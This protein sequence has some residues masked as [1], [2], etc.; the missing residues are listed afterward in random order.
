VEDKVCKELDRLQAHLEEVRGQIE[1]VCKA[2]RTEVEENWYGQKSR[3][4]PGELAL[5]NVLSGFGMRFN[6]DHD[7]A[8]LAALM[9]PNEIDSTM[10]SFIEELGRI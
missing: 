7:A 2:K 5:D 3:L 1:G 10:K 4:I 8:R 9:E 6:K